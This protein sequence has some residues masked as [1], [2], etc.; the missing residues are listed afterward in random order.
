VG[1]SGTHRLKKY[2]AVEL[3]S[4]D[5]KTKIAK[6]EKRKSCCMLTFPD[7]DQV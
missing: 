6:D 2:Q 5:R 4:R 3:G 1:H 7:I